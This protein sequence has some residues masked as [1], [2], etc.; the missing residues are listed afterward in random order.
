MSNTY[1][2]DANA[3]ESL[4]IQNALAGTMEEMSEVNIISMSLGPLYITNFKYKKKKRCL[5]KIAAQP[6]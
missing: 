1:L 3:T 2:V 5:W 4:V 6:T